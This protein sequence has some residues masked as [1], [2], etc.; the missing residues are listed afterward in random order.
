[1]PFLYGFHVPGL[2]SAL[3]ALK[4]LHSN[5]VNLVTCLAVYGAVHHLAEN[6]KGMNRTPHK[7][8]TLYASNNSFGIGL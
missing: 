6:V 3:T 2:Q 4:S 1:M 5:G 7:L 8:T